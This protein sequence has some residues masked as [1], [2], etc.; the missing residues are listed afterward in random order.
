MLR[1]RY[2]HGFS[3]TLWCR[4]L[5]TSSAN[6][7][8][9]MWIVWRYT[10][11][12]ISPIWIGHFLTDLFI[13]LGKVPK[14]IIYDDACH[15]QPFCETRIDQQNKKSLHFQ[16]KKYVVDKLHMR[17]HTGDACKK[18]N[19][20]ALYPELDDKNTVVCEQVNFWLVKFKHV[21]KHMIIDL[22]FSCM[23]Y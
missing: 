3:G 5:Y 14:Y 1:H 13:V 15:L 10:I 7:Y 21:L 18:N 8:R 19:D 17:G 23:L 4:I 16:D 2:N 6:V 12:F 22:T 9:P 20:P 11:L